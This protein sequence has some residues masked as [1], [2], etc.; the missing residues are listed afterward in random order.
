[1]RGVLL[2]LVGLVAGCGDSTR[3]ARASGA[4]DEVLASIDGQPITAGDLQRRLD[5]LDGYSRARYSAPEQKRRFLENVVRF[6]VLAREAQ[7]RGYD[8]DP[9]V[10]RTLKNQMVTALLQ[11][12]LYDKLRPEDIPEA[13]VERYYREH[14]QEFRQPAEVR[15]SQIFTIDE[16]KARRAEAA[17][18]G[19]R[20]R[21]ETDRAFR[22]LVAQMS[23]DEDSKSR[24]GDLTFFARTT[25]T[26]P[27]ALVEAAFALEKIGDV[28]PVVHTDR[29]YH[30]LVLT[31]RR[32]TFT[33]ALPEVSREIRKLLVRERGNQKMEELVAEMRKRMKVE[34]YEDRLAR[35]TPAPAPAAP[36]APPLPA[37]TGGHP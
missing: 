12:E 4:S 9:E 2:V 17:A 7:S 36:V 16:V 21:P 8:R 23:E 14:T 31:Q 25:T 13:E 37:S 34:I 33:R 6:E 27:P 26:Y 15:V 20:G 10:Q 19:L 24:G 29:G 22:E 1:M 11:K 30:V 35:V 3:P 18:R 32:P 28:S 5:A